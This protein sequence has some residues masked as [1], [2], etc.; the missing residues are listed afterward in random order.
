MVGNDVID[1][2]DREVIEGPTHP[3][4]D[5]RVFAAA[6]RALLRSSRSPGLLRWTLW[7]AK[8][9]AYKLARKR[10]SRVIFSPRRFVVDL[11][12][13]DRARIHHGSIEFTVRIASAGHALHA[14]A[15]DAGRGDDRLVWAVEPKGRDADPSRAAR[16]LA[17]RVLGEELELPAEAFRFGRHGRVPTLAV[18]GRRGSLDLSLSHHGRFVAFACQVGIAA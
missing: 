14:L 6:E 1:L 9:A 4:F 10:N 8:E 3:R 2:G 18:E 5:Q 16:A 13:A 17:A 12:Q 11:E 15:Q 7:S